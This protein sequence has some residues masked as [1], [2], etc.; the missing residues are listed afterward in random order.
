LYLIRSLLI[1]NSF[2]TPP[3]LE[4]CDIFSQTAKAKP[5]LLVIVIFEFVYLVDE[6]WNHPKTKYE[7]RMVK[8]P[9]I[10]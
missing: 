8:V 2:F 7:T 4:L 6:C 5:S 3:P 1:S 10:V 9:K